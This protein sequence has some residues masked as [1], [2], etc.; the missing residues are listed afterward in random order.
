[1]IVILIL[2]FV[3]IA[4]ADFP[5]LLKKNKKREFV[6]LLIFYILAFTISAMQVFGVK[7]PSPV[8]GIKFFIKDVLGLKYSE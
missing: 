1:M 8:P 5:V 7:I 3:L 6:I 2:V 4:L